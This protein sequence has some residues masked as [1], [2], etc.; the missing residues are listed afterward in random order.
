MMEK[1]SLIDPGFFGTSSDNIVVLNDFIDKKDLKTIQDFCPTITKFEQIPGDNW[2]NRVCSP[3]LLF[4]QSENIL[5][6]MLSYQNKLKSKIESHFNLTL[7]PNVVSIVVWRPGD[8]Q[9]PHAD[10]QLNDGSPNSYP[11]NDIASLMYL[12]DD[13]IGGEIYFPDHNLSL[14]P[15]AGSAVFF[16]G[17]IHYLHGVTAVT[18]GLRFTSPT[19]WTVKELGSSTSQ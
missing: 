1:R 4:K 12:T 10:K 17:D 2:D 14:R 8:G 11:E 16:P 18:E 7:H 15:K 9:L 19:F 3:N 5:N 6:L 13:Y